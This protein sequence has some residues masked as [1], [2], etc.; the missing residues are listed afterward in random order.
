MRAG[1]RWRTNFKTTFH[2]WQDGEPQQVPIVHFEM[3]DIS[4]LLASTGTSFLTSFVIH[5]KKNPCNIG[6]NAEARNTHP[7]CYWQ[8][9]FT[10]FC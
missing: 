6:Y 5:G 3:N 7:L 9:Q 10:V 4:N 2:K 1:K 8:E